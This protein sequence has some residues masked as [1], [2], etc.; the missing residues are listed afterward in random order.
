MSKIFERKKYVYS[1]AERCNSP[2]FTKLGSLP[3]HLTSNQNCSSQFEEQ[4]EEK[5]TITKQVAKED[6]I[7]KTS[8]IKNILL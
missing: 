8:M 1:F 5:S 2:I 4:F 6:S 7:H 3:A